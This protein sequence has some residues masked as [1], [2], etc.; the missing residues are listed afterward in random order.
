MDILGE[1]KHY[2]EHNM[3]CEEVD[4]L[5]FICNKTVIMFSQ[6]DDI[7]KM[8]LYSCGIWQVSY[9]FITDETIYEVVKT[10]KSKVCDTENYL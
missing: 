9:L 7:L 2:M 6:Q 10:I 1:V 5:T 4:E 3:C 8:S